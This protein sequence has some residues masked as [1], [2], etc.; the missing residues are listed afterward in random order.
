M[1]WKQQRCFGVPVYRVAE[2]KTALLSKCVESEPIWVVIH[3]G[4]E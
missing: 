1:S 4:L 3:F 2:V